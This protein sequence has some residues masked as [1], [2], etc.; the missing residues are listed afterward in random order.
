MSKLRHR[1]DRWSARLIRGAS[2]LVILAI[3]G[4]FLQ[5][6]TVAWPLGSLS[7]IEPTEAVARAGGV[8]R[9]I[10]QT[11]DWVPR[12][13][14]AISWSDSTNRRI[15]IAADE[16]GDVFGEIIDLRGILPGSRKEIAVTPLAG[17]KLLHPADFVM[18]DP[19]DPLI[20]CAVR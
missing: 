14:A 5:M 6:L 11:P 13:D 4:M 15:W 1:V 8:G 17:E 19:F 16:V 2:V 18:L 20:P 12:I 7:S 10:R 3:V 9:T